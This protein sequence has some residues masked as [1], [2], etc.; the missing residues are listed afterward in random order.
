MFFIK[1]FFRIRARFGRALMP[2]TNVIMTS[3]LLNA[4]HK[5]TL[6]IRISLEF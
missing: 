2:F 5:Y 1:Y 3:D 6:S 4:S